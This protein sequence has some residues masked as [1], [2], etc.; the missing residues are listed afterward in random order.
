MLRC[1]PQSD[2][3]H[4]YSSFLSSFS[5]SLSQLAFY[6]LYK[7]EE[8]GKCTEK[9]PSR[10]QLTARAKHDAWA[11]LGKSVNERASRHARERIREAS[12]MMTASTYC[13]RTSHPICCCLSSLLFSLS[14]SMSKADAQAQYI[15]ALT[16]ID[17]T[18]EAKSDAAAKIKSKL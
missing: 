9:Q 14:D 13:A 1:A 12:R 15:A 2:R 5:F 16:K 18:W 6:G 8:K 17:P 3:H 11:K 10:L 7:Q 4:R